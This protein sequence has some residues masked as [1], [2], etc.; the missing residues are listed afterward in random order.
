VETDYTVFVPILYTGVTV[1]R[2]L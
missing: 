1:C 2:Q